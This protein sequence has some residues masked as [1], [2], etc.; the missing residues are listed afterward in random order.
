M[1]YFYQADFYSL[2]YDLAKFDASKF[3]WKSSQAKDSRSQKFA[4][5]ILI[6]YLINISISHF[7]K[8]CGE[9]WRRQTKVCR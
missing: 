4:T 5:G 3:T 8:V 7:L 9:K 1:Y 2:Y 6:L